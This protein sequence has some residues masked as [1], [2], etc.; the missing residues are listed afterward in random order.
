MLAS[1]P[2]RRSIRWVA[3]LV[4]GFG[5]ACGD[6][7]GA[8]PAPVA[9]ETAAAP[10]AAPPTATAPVAAT[11]YPDSTDGLIALGTDLAAAARG[12]DEQAL[13]RLL[14]SLRLR[15]PEAW[16]DATFGKTLGAALA[17]EYR[18]TREEIGQLA[19]VIE[20]LHQ[21]GLVRLTAE[22]FV[23]ADDPASVG[24]Q[25]AA[26]AKMARPTPLYSL[27]LASADGARVFHLWSFVHHGGTFRYVGKMRRTVDSP[28]GGDRD[29]LELRLRDRASAASR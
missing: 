21:D 11:A 3:C 19:T 16:F 20:R 15:D 28:A 13:A 10:A 6:D 7:D 24:Y 12:K 9:I 27:R 25:S 17:T 14:E 23:A 22:R 8:K 4:A 18:P 29:P 1:M 5:A 2:S 26:L